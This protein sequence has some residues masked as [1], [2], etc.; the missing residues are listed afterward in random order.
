MLLVNNTMKLFV[1]V[2]VI[3]LFQQSKILSQSKAEL[4][5]K[6]AENV[7]QLEYSRGILNKMTKSKNASLHEINLI[8]KTIIVR[9][10]L[11]ENISG[12]I[13][14]LEKDISSNNVEISRIN[15]RIDIIMKDYAALIRNSYKMLDHD[16]SL[17]YILSSQDINQ[18]YMRI[19][20]I[21]HLTGYRKSLIASLDSEKMNII[22]LNKELSENKIN[23]E[24]LLAE[25]KKEIS[26]LDSDRKK[27]LNIVRNLKSKE[28]ELRREIQKRERIMLQVENEMKKLIEAEARK[29]KASGK[30]S[31]LTAGEVILSGEFSKNQGKLPWPTEKGI[32]TGKFGKQKHTILKGIEFESNGIDITTSNGTRVR[33]VFDGEVTRVVAIMGANYTVIIRH[34]QYYSVYQNLIN[35]KV[36]SGDKVKTGEFI[37]TVF[38]DMENISKIHFEIWKDKNILNPELWLRM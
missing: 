28:A 3:L 18:G 7:E 9:E 1:L 29:A 37:G 6:K 33:S 35:V 2:L 8:E 25:R 34:G 38:T 24:K 19:K 4:E 10:N 20:Y 14:I 21:R 32:L 23:N 22:N 17:M 31:N 16:Y 26:Q 36:K 15:E 5:K 30:I 11:V 12:E 13:G 27:R